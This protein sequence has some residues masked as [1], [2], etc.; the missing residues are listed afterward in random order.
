VKTKA[1]RAAKLN[2][3]SV[4]LVGEVDDRAVIQ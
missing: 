4:A 2:V 3:A 1:N